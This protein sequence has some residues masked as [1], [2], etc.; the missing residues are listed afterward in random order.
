MNNRIANSKKL[1][2][3]E[4]EFAQY[5]FNK[6]QKNTNSKNDVEKNL[7]TEERRMKNDNSFNH[8]AVFSVV[9]NALDELELI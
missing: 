3:E 8:T 6:V 9:F 4:K 2:N 7:N 1:N 5:I